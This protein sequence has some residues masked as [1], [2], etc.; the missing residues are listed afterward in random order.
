MLEPRRHKYRDLGMARHA[1]TN[2]DAPILLMESKDG[3]R[4]TIFRG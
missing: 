3:H 1:P 2:Y 4:F